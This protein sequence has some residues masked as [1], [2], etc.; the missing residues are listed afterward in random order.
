MHSLRYQ[1]WLL[2]AIVLA[3]FCG[4]GAK[5]Q[6]APKIQLTEG[7]TYALIIDKKDTSTMTINSNTLRESIEMHRI[8]DIVVKEARADGGAVL[9]V[10]YKSPTVTLSISIRGVELPL[11]KNAQGRSF[12]EVIAEIAKGHTFT[13]DLA[14]DGTILSVNGL[15]ELQK[16]IKE[17]VNVQD[18]VGGDMASPKQIE[19]FEKRMFDL[20][21]P[22]YIAL[23]FGEIFSVLPT[24]PVEVGD[25]W[26]VPRLEHKMGE[27]YYDR[28]VSATRVE[29]NKLYAHLK[30]TMASLPTAET[31][32]TGHASSDITI[33]LNTGLVMMQK[34]TESLSGSNATEG[35]SDIKG[36]VNTTIEIIKM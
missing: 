19:E 15:D 36:K 30:A 33:D 26:N 12:Y 23:I 34:L 2:S 10:T 21:S 17:Q 13:L 27:M 5:Q 28:T 9:A 4:C 6:Y 8:Y 32:V 18:F 14:A 3:L 31:Q 1:R 35:V 25:T 24:T 11:L 29:G 20:E 7:D 16:T 22:D